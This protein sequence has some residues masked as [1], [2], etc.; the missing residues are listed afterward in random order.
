VG[1]DEHSLTSEPIAA[2]RWRCAKERPIATVVETP[3][4]VEIQPI[5]DVTRVALAGMATA[6]AMTLVIAAALRTMQRH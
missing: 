4:R 2:K 1:T 6:L 5:I 3:Q